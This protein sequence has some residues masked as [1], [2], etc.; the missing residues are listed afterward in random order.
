MSTADE[1]AK[2]HEL[3]RQGALTQDEFERA[4]AGLLAGVGAPLTLNP[5]R[6][7]NGDRWIAGVCGGI[8]QATGVESWIWR[9]LMV[10]GL[11]LGGATALLYLILWMFVPRAI[12]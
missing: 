1:I 7:S 3:L 6:L 10:G 4:K 11:F 8:A 5:L 12:E 2:L 9:L